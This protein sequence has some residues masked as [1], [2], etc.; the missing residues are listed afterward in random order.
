MTPSDFVS[1]LIRDFGEQSG[2][3]RNQDE[4]ATSIQWK[5]IGLAVSH[6]FRS[7]PGCRTMIGPMNIEMKPCKQVTRK[8]RA[9]PSQSSRPEELD[10]SAT[11]GKTDTD[12]NM[13]T[14]F[15]ILRKNR[16][17]NLQNLIL[18]RNSF[19]QTVENLFALSFL[20]KDGRA[21]IT[22]GEEGCHLVSPKNAP[23]ANAILSGEV[24]YSHFSFRFDFGDWKLMLASVEDGEELMPHRDE[25]SVQPNSDSEEAQAIYPTTPIKKLSRNRDLVRHEQTVVEDSPENR[26]ADASQLAI[27]KGKR[28]LL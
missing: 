10:E 25:V 19:A 24:S 5:D 11:E 21:E 2:P 17:V 7:A 22:V 8:K 20:V 18:N 15:D 14:M 27:R 6:V 3:N 1:S 26:D 28:K 23:G 16:K 12:R 13:A 4:D 9:R